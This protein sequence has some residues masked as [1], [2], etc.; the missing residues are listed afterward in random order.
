MLGAVICVYDVLEDGVHDAANFFFF[1]HCSVVRDMNA[2]CINTFVQ[3]LG[4]Q[5]PEEHTNEAY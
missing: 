1:K 5:F 2:N 3:G 4:F